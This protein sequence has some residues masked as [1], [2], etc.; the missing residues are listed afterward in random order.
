MV[1]CFCIKSV[2]Y[3]SFIV[4]SFWM[5]K[6]YAKCESTLFLCF[7]VLLSVF[8]GPLFNYNTLCRTARCRAWRCVKAMALVT[9][10]ACPIV[11]AWANFL[12]KS[13]SLRH[14]GIYVY[15]YVYNFLI[16]VA[17]ILSFG[18]ALRGVYFLCSAPS[19]NLRQARLQTI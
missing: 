12:W 11:C 3:A 6:H 16:V 8:N 4:C 18:G 7:N 15:M 19:R 2:C 5:I 14:C 10:T 1:C 17:C 9:V 13:D